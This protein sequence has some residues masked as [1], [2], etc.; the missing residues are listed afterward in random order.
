[1]A[2]CSPS[3]RLRI[4]KLGNT[5]SFKTLETRS[6]PVSTLQGLLLIDQIVSVSDL[7][8]KVQLREGVTDDFLVKTLR[9]FNVNKGER[10]F[11][12]VFDGLVTRLCHP[13]PPPVVSPLPPQ[14]H[15]PPPSVPYVCEDLKGFLVLEDP[16]F[17]LKLDDLSEITD[18]IPGDAYKEWVVGPSGS[19]CALV[20]YTHQVFF[21]P[22]RMF[23]FEGVSYRL[24]F[25]PSR[26][27][28]F[29]SPRAARFPLGRALMEVCSASSSAFPDEAAK[30][31]LF[32][33]SSYPPDVLV[34]LESPPVAKDPIIHMEEV[35][36]EG[37]GE[38][39]DVEGSETDTS[40]EGEVSDGSE[41]GDPD[42]SGEGDKNTTTSGGEEPRRNGEVVSA[43]AV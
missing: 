42:S 16:P 2:P 30:S 11:H 32:V 37:E 18:K 6:L 39:G 22:P 21:V 20:S 19:T 12:S 34:S 35:E 9:S 27:A 40:E 41:K 29:L 24:K 5:G 1:M 4:I 17:H 26:P 28:Q 43:G 25:F 36:E 3:N 31:V 38:E 13:P 10:Q 8:C 15:G 33:L 14:I 23:F 7:T